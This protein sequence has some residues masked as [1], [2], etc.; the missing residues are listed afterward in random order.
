MIDSMVT[1]ICQPTSVVHEVSFE[2]F[3]FAMMMEQ[4]TRHFDTFYGAVLAHAGQT[5]RT[6]VRSFR[7]WKTVSG[8]SKD[9]VTGEVGSLGNET[10]A[11][12][13]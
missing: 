12:L 8:E 5:G 1:M 11:G 13:V 9:E 6:S 2:S 3:R 7:V 10:V 4:K